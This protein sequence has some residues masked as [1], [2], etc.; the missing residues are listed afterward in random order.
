MKVQPVKIEFK[1]LY[2]H[3]H[4]YTDDVQYNS[5]IISNLI[6]QSIMLINIDTYEKLDGEYKRAIAINAACTLENNH[7]ILFKDGFY[8]LYIN[9]H[10]SPTTCKVTYSWGESLLSFNM[11]DDVY[12]LSIME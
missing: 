4:L 2:E 11:Y 1:I 10:I 3:R 7:K 6:N 8:Q 9:Y 5:L 12:L